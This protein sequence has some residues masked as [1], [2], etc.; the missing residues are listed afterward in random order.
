MGSISNAMC[1]K[2]E[3][4]EEDEGGDLIGRHEKR[5]DGGRRGAAVIWGI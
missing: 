2:R 3:Q 1:Y 4:D 5:G